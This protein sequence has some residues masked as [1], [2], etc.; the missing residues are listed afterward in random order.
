MVKSLIFSVLSCHNATA[1]F[2]LGYELRMPRSSKTCGCFAED[3]II[4][5][6]NGTD[7][8]LLIPYGLRISIVIQIIN[9]RKSQAL[10]LT[11]GR[12][13][14]PL[15]LLLKKREISIVPDGVLS[16]CLAEGDKWSRPAASKSTAGKSMG[17]SL[18]FPSL[19]CLML[20]L[21]KFHRGSTQICFEIWGSS[22]QNI[23]EAHTS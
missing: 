2:L 19:Y 6:C 21:S 15:E 22:V 14:A 10:V 4:Q 13:W 7:Q 23:A 8:I 3:A 18:I 12:S 5:T 11:T 9:N 16:V 17:S 20:I 1:V